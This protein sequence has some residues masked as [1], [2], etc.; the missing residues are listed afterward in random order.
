MFEHIVL[1]KFKPDASIEVQEN[2]IKLAY[3]F[4][5]NIPGIVQL[6]AGINATEEI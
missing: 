2:A 4:K 6:S 1:L 3:D 5:G